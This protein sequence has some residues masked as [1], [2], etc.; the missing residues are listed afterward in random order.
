[1]TLN[2][3]D[4]HPKSIDFTWPTCAVRIYARYQS[5]YLNFLNILDL[6]IL[7]KNQV[8]KNHKFATLKNGILV[9]IL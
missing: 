9:S 4:I 5:I 7:R 1:M 3:E 8:S 2:L 6:K